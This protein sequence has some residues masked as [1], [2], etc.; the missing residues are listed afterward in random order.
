MM[1]SIEYR[2]IKI[3]VTVLFLIAMFAILFIGWAEDK[4]S[5]QR[6]VIPRAQGNVR[7]QVTYDFLIDAAEAREA[8]ARYENGGQR[9]NDLET[10]HKY[11]DNAA[12][13]HPVP[14]P[15]CSKFIPSDH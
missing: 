4:R 14:H 10:A 3:F 6:Q 12:R 11:R 9:L 5:C 13:L 7:E 15:E 1:T 8:S 2:K